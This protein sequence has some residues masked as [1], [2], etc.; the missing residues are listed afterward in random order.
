MQNANTY[1]TYIV[2]LFERFVV[3]Y[4][5]DKRLGINKCEIT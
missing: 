3:R 4:F 5:E 2:K 1:K